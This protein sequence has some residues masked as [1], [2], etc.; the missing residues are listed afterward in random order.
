VGA[1]A[2]KKIAEPAVT[3]TDNMSAV[4]E[5][6]CTVCGRPSD[7]RMYCSG[8]CKQRAYRERK[9]EETRPPLRLVMAEAPAAADDPMEV[10]RQIEKAC[11]ACLL[12]AVRSGDVRAAMFV[13]SRK[14]PRKWGAR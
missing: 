9:R 5:P 6:R 14:F 1:A 3:V 11:V 7:G 12:Q 2:G 10:G 4:A 13:L 8:R